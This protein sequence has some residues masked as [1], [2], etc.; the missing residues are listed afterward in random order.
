MTE[1]VIH[2]IARFLASYE[3]KYQ[4]NL[5]INA[6]KEIRTVSNALIESLRQPARVTI[7]RHTKED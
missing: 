6:M 2:Y 7:H 4:T 5:H 1:E 3:D